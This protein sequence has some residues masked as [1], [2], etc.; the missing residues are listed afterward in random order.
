LTHLVQN[1]IA[2]A[3]FRQVGNELEE[4][5]LQLTKGEVA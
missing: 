5:F 1:G 4:L 3:E 2:V